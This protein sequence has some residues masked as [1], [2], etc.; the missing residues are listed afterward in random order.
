MPITQ[1]LVM[2]SCDMYNKLILQILLKNKKV[3]SLFMA[4]MAMPDVRTYSSPIEFTGILLCMGVTC[5]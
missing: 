1:A 4:A 2:S 5:H 3:L